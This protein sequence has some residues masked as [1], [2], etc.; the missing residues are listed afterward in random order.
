MRNRQTPGNEML[1]C[2]ERGYRLGYSAIY[3]G[4]LA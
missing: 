2:P 3:G 4:V 1:C